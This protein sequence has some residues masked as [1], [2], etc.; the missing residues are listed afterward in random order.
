MKSQ[1]IVILFKLLSL[2]EQ[3]KFGSP[4]G[5]G[6]LSSSVDPYAVRSLEASLGIS[7]TEIS[8]SLK[9]SIGSKLAAKLQGITRANRRNLAEFV[10]HGLK[11]AFPVKPSA[12]QRGIPT[13]FAAP[14]LKGQLVSAGEEIYVWPYPEGQK[15]GLAVK[16][17]FRSV[18]KAALADERLYEY[19]A[20]ADAL[21][22]GG[23]RESGLAKEMLETRIIGQ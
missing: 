14:M 20:L 18:P 3:E 1:D 19:L 4:N 15:R 23:P 9:R 10:M 22:L 8:A 16:P 7:K 6:E 21:R 11:Y 12:P 2:E 17:L 5:Y 13:A